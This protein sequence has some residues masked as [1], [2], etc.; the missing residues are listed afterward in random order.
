MN[1]AFGGTRVKLIFVYNARAG[2]LAGLMDSIHKTLSPDTYPCGLCAITYGAL[3]MK[4]T[5]RNWLKSQ[6]FE[7]EFRYR[8]AFRASYPGVDA[9]LPAIFVDRDTRLEMLVAASDFKTASTV[10][11]LIALIETRLATLSPATP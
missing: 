11:D 6:P 5:W 9:A 4:P 2:M 10:D 3:A 7:S 8:A 1:R